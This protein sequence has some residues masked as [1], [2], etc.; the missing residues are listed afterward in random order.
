MAR[1]TVQVPGVGFYVSRDT[2]NTV[3]LPGGGFFADRTP[4]SL[5]VQLWKGAVEPAPA[6]GA[7]LEVQ[8][9]KGAVEPVGVAVAAAALARS[10]GWV[11]A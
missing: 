10:Y 4:V 5:V 1:I 3:Q 6:G 7:A 11:S 8:S 9:W 2:G